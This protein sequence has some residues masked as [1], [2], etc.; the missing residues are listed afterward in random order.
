MYTSSSIFWV[1]IGV[2]KKLLNE[3]G[4]KLS[5]SLLAHLLN[6]LQSPKTQ[7]HSSWREIDA[8]SAPSPS[9]ISN[10]KPTACETTWLC[11]K[12]QCF[13]GHYAT[14][15]SILLH[16]NQSRTPPTGG[17]LA[18]LTYLFHYICYYYIGY[19]LAGHCEAI[20]EGPD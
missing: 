13:T 1:P 2:Q 3:R 20:T 7:C 9:S 11:C 16:L 6:C 8:I 10:I 15:C 19:Y 4:L 17:T 14:K 5:G 18:L 12:A